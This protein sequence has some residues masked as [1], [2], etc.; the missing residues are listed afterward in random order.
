M[1]NPSIVPGKQSSTL[2]RAAGSIGNQPPSTFI[3]NGGSR[4]SS[5]IGSRSV[6]KQQ[7]HPLPEYGALRASPKPLKKM[8]VMVNGQQQQQIMIEKYGLD[9]TE[10]GIIILTRKKD[11]EGNYSKKM[12]LREVRIN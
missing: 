9:N 8:T 1:P 5:V 12:S 4:P 11:F 10:E 3:N 7:F 6:A 2:P